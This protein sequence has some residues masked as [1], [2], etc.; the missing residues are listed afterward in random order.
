MSDLLPL[1]QTL[2]SVAVAGLTLWLRYLSH[3]RQKE[4]SFREELARREEKLREEVEKLSAER[5]AKEKEML[6]KIEQLKEESMNFREVVH[7]M[8]LK[9]S[10]ITVEIKHIS[11]SLDKL[12]DKLQP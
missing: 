12:L 7:H 3:M 6:S 11:S 9:I 4:K 10:E 8:E 1:V 2:I 5:V